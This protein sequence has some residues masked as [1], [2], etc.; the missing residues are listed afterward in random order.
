MKPLSQLLRFQERRMIESVRSFVARRQRR[1]SA[2]A[3]LIALACALTSSV[4]SRSVLL[5]QGEPATSRVEVL[6]WTHQAE[7]ENLYQRVIEAIESLVS[8]L[9][10]NETDAGDPTE[11]E[12]GGH[13]VTLSHEGAELL[14]GARLLDVAPAR[15]LPRGATLVFQEAGNPLAEQVPDVFTITPDSWSFSLA[16]G[17]ASTIV[18]RRFLDEGI[19]IRRAIGAGTAD[20]AFVSPPFD[21]RR[22]LFSQLEFEQW[23]EHDEA[24]S[25]SS[26]R[27]EV[28]S[29]FAPSGSRREAVALGAYLF[30]S[31]SEPV[32]HDAGD[33]DDDGRL[34]IT[35]IYLIAGYLFL[36]EAPPPPPFPDPGVDPTKD[37]LP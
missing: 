16:D 15:L 20:S 18:A 37:D 28:D 7:R 1:A 33:T 5:G 22:G 10:V 2:V 26:S 36:G 27:T 32:P 11:L 4:S 12:R 17:E 6:A 21:Q 13:I 29:S 3:R 31:G 35:D 34:T 9:T 24:A 14:R 23:Y 8:D 25:P 30:R 19:V